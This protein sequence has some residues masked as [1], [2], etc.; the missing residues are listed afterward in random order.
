MSA[1]VVRPRQRL[2]KYRIVRRIGR[3]GY[4]D[5]YEAMD[6]IEGLRV[7]LKIPSAEAL[8]PAVLEEVR[9]EIRLAAVLDHPNVLPLKN[10]DVLDGRLVIA[11]PLGIETLERRLARRLGMRRALELADQILAGLACA[12]EHGIIHCDIKPDNILLFDDGTA[13]IADFGIAKV[14]TRTL[15]ASGTGTVGYM[16][17]EQ[18]MG[19]PSPRSDVFAAGM[20]L[21]RMFTGVLPQ[22]PLAWPLPG[23]R[24][25]RRV[26]AE[27]TEVLRRALEVDPRRRYRDAGAM[28]R[29]FRAARRKVTA[30]TKPAA[31]AAGGNGVAVGRDWR[32]V[33]ARQY[34]R[35]VSDWL[36]HDDDCPACG[37][38]FD[39]R[40]TH[41]P[42]CGQARPFY[43]GPTTMPRR[44]E[45]CGRGV[46]LD[47]KYC[48][49]CYGAAIGPA[50]GRT[51]TDRRYAAR[52]TSAR[53][54]RKVLIPF[55]RYCPWCR[56][57]VRRRWKI[58]GV[59]GQCR[60]CGSSVVAGF[61]SHCAFCG[62]ALP[63]KRNTR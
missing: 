8:S 10:A 53:C 29:A 4:A 30:R 5:V 52:C 9:R 51:Y 61:W 46:K 58:P 23:H 38:P 54:T 36:R 63:T 2:G 60:R 57:K 47:W 35:L 24:R 45:R 7:A 40:M 18:A 11:Y 43:D 22:W 21:Y 32:R 19:R 49:H 31:R 44:C 17:P 59:G 27:V 1:P 25:L 62:S 12:H 39:E 55:S 56:T 37:E 15:Q 41:C 28:L 42:F 3:G 34:R 48:A 50:S 6:T 20:V 26:G 33:R 13:K 14:G 16:A